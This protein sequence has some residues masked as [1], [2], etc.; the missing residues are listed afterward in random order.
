M[1]SSKKV[2]LAVRLVLK[3]LEDNDG[4]TVTLKYAYV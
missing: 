3:V 1:S 2:P 4:D